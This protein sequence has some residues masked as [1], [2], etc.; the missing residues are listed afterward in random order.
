MN[1]KPGLYKHF[2]GN[3]YQLISYAKHSEDTSEYVVYRALYGDRDLWV[4][5]AEMWDETL[6]RDGKSFKRFT[7]V[8]D[9]IIETER[10]FLRKLTEDDYDALYA[11]LGDS[12]IMSHYPYTFDEKRVRV[13]IEKNIDR[14]ETF[15]FGLFAACLKETGEMIGDCGLTMQNIN[16]MI[17]P[18]IGYHF[19]KD[20]QRKGFAKEA[21]SAVR[22]WA[23]ENTPFQKIYSYMK[24]DNIPSSATAKSIGMKLVDEYID[25]EKEYT[26]VYVISKGEWKYHV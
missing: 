10:L 3:N 14:Y 18:E 1:N 7:E 8:S 12:E 21:A 15:G 9:R 4:R 20:M 5:P 13:W 17:K 16:G 25:D 22:D 24:K 11:V 2:K 26:Q 19:R 6:E 23:F